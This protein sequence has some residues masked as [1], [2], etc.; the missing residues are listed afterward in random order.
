MIAEEFRVLAVK[1]DG[2]GST[3]AVPHSFLSFCHFKGL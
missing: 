1:L 3:M 2:L